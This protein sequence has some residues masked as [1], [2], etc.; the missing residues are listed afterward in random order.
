[1]DESLAKRYI[2]SPEMGHHVLHHHRLAG[3]VDQLGVV[4]V[5]PGP[6]HLLRRGLE[7]GVKFLANLQRLAD[8]RYGCTKFVGEL[9]V[10]LTSHASLANGNS[11]LL[12]P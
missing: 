8:C 7:L 4:L 6:S 11:V 3:L 9:L 1:M 10:S 2:G 12:R 5:P